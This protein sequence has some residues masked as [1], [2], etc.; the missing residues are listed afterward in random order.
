MKL[1]ARFLS[2]FIIFSFILTACQATP[3]PAPT[4]TEAPV[5]TPVETVSQPTPQEPEEEPLY[6]AIIWH[7]HQ[8]LYYKDEEG[9]YT[10]PW[11]RVHATKDYYDMAAMLKDYPSV[12]VTFNLT[13]VLIRQLNDF[14]QN[15]AKDRYWVLAEKPAAELTTAEKDFIL[16]RFF[17]ANWDRIIKVYPGYKA[18]LD[19]RAGTDDAAIARAL[20]I[21]TEQDFRDLQ[22]WFNLAWIDPD[23]L[24]KEPLKTLVEKDHNFTEEDKQVLFSEIKRIMAQVL[25]VH[26]ELQDAGQIE[27]I[28]T[29]YAHP[30][31]PLIYDTNLALAGNSSAELPEGRFFYP[32][33]VQAHLEKA[34]EIYTQTFGKPPRGMWPGEGAVAQEIVPFVAN[35][36]FQ[37]MATGEYVLAKSLDMESFTRDATETVQQADVLYRPYIVQGKTGGPVEG[38]PVAIIFRDLVISDKIGFTYSGMDGE[39]AAKDFMNRLENIRA[40][41]QKEG[42]KGPHLVS[43]ILD[44]ENAWEYYDRDGKAF[45]NAL[46][47]NLSESKTIQTITP[48]EFLEKYPEQKKLDRLFPSAWFSPNFDTWIG[49]PEEREAWNY[50]LR[51]RQ[52][53]DGAI[54]SGKLTDEQ[55]ATAKDFMYLAEGSDWF[56]W[57]GADQNS[58]N[59]DYFDVGYRALLAE[60][61]KAI[62]KEIPEFV[63]VPIIQPNPVPAATPL[64]G[65]SSPTVDGRETSDEWA[66]AALFPAE[67]QSPVQGFALALDKQNLYVKVNLVPSA[68]PVERI[69][70]YLSSPRL[71]GSYAFTRV[72]GDE[73]KVLLPVLANRLMEW[74]GG[75][76]LKSYKAGTNRWDYEEET[77]TAASGQVVEF[78]IPLSKLGELEAGDELRVAVVAMPAGQRLPQSGPAQLILPEISSAEVLFEVSDPEKDDH[79]PGTYTYPTNGVFLPQVFDLKSFSV[80][81][82]E[83]NVIF[84]FAFYGAIPNPW[85][86]GLN[87]SLQTLDVYIDKDP[88]KGTGARL[89]LPGRNAALASGNGWEY[90]VWAEGWTPGIFAPDPQTLEPKPV[91][92]SS[93]KIIVDPVAQTVTL[94]VPRQIFGE[95]DPATWGYVAAVLSQEGYPSTGVWRVRDVQSSSAEW[96]FGGAPDDTNHTRIIDLIWPPDVSPTQEEMLSQYPPSKARIDELT[97]DDFPQVQLLMKR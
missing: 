90:V 55:L 57:Y 34:V 59:D 72:S 38:G 66:K 37:W 6:L 4:A 23:E 5:P 84:K 65:L 12:K 81:A 25:P 47:R 48:S 82:D 16:R 94:R 42:A 85:G 1:L 76:A 11:V 9:I 39:A 41:L 61:Y 43:V 26:R 62:G 35:A 28:T 73:E 60:V 83:K 52:A 21:F 3:T 44:G 20:E 45:L 40:R 93:Y 67:G 70:V 36:G 58:G 74:E 32:Q 17:D 8:P 31:L 10:R 15:G 19:K 80:S 68:Q 86:S 29:P 53:L 24:A 87:L 95:G 79:G 88:G 64:V 97:A 91:P 50:L 69:G 2:I 96:R 71:K 63:Q 33:D 13:P 18:L 46:Y 75:K 78:S 77:G 51:T 27:V 54:R 14:V 7:Q 92:D 30:I 89:M 56:W 22:I 49:E